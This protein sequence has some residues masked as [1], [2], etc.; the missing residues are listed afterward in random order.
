MKRLRKK[1][2]GLTK[3]GQNLVLA[4]AGVVGVCPCSWTAMDVGSKLEAFVEDDC[5]PT[6]IATCPFADKDFEG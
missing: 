5:G 2:G 1:D 4:V 6:H 3:A